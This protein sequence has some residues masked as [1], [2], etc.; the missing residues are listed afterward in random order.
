MSYRGMDQ[1]P[2]IRRIQ[3][4]SGKVFIVLIACVVS[5]LLLDLT[6]RFFISSRSSFE[7]K[8]PVQIYRKPYPYIMFRGEPYG[9]QG[10][11]VL[12]E[13]GYMGAAPTKV[14]KPG[15]FR[16]IFLG[17]STLVEGNPTIPQ[18]VEMEFKTN[19]SRDVRTFNFGVVS[20]VSSM[21]VARIVFEASD[22]EPDLIIMYNG[23]N[24]MTHPYWWDPRPGYPFNFIVYENNPLLESD[25]RKYP[26][27]SLLAY[28]SNLLR[29]LGRKYFE[30]QFANLRQKREEIH[31]KTVEWSQQISEVYIA[32]LV[33]ASRISHAFKSEFIAFFQPMVY[34]KDKLSEEERQSVKQ[35]EFEYHNL[36][37]QQVSTSSRLTIDKEDIAFVDLS[38]IYDDVN[39]TVFEDEVHTNQ[40]SKLIIAREIYQQIMAKFPELKNPVKAELEKSDALRN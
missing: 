12:N 1:F 26:G 10:Q 6:S 18:L 13:I 39:E 5:F 28:E 35:D 31:F 27:F 17:G 9:K 15:E 3:L 14:K 8:F 32:N 4:V 30:Y 11:I 19:Q 34:Y 29:V 16:I 38:D 22:Y 21:E 36:M 33:K 25:V 23:A 37:R 7:Q 40:Q 24:D 2:T 20:S